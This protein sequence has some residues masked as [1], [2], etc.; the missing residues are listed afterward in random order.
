VP[1]SPLPW[2]APKEIKSANEIDVIVVAKD[3]FL[4][5]T[6]TSNVCV[7]LHDRQ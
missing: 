2:G 7:K 3:S 6:P 5:I 1:P 4:N